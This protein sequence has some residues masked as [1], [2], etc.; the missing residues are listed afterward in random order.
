MVNMSVGNATVPMPIAPLVLPVYAV[1]APAAAVVNEFDGWR[2]ARLRRGH[3]GRVR[4]TCAEMA[5]KARP[6]ANAR[7]NARIYVFIGGPKPPMFWDGG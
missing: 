3:L 2:G 4:A 7:V 5:A 1:P 6:T